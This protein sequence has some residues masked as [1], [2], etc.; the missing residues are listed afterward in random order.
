M[1]QSKFKIVG[2]LSIISEGF[3]EYTPNL[4]KE[5]RGMST[6]NFL[7]SFT[8]SSKQR[9]GK[10]Y[11]PSVPHISIYKNVWFTGFTECSY[12][13]TRSCECVVMF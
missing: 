7:P 8:W 6:C 13:F 4:I 2:K 11:E 5:N 12:L 1:N 10:Y 3:I 9:A